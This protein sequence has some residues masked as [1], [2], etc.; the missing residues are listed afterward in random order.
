M[1]QQNSKQITVDYKRLDRKVHIELNILFIRVAP[2]IL[3]ENYF[4]K[5]KV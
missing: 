1:I 5:Q 2:D 4:D 3:L